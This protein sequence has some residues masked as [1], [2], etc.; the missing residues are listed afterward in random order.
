MFKARIRWMVNMDLMATCANKPATL[1]GR[2]NL[3]E[4]TCAN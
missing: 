1:I 3:G 2:A 4:Q